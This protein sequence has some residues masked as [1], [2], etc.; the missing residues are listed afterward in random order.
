MKELWTGGGVWGSLVQ[1]MALRDG[2]WA[3][4]LKR[5]LQPWLILKLPVKWN[6]S[7]R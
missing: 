3:V 6:G 5:E 1:W 4:G 7:L 2:W